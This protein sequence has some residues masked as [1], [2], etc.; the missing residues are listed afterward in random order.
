MTRA[1]A[2]PTGDLSL[3]ALTVHL[4]ETRGTP[5]LGR[6][7]EC[8]AFTTVPLAYSLVATFAEDVVDAGK[9]AGDAGGVELLYEPP[10]AGPVVGREIGVT[11]GM[12]YWRFVQNGLSGIASGPVEGGVATLLVP[13]ADVITLFD[14]A[15]N[16]VFQ[17]ASGA[18]EGVIGGSTSRVPLDGAPI[19]SALASE[20]DNVYCRST[21]TATTSSVHVWSLSGGTSATLLH[22]LP[23]G[24]AFAADDQRLYFS[25]D[26]GFASQATIEAT[27][28]FGDGG[29]PP[30]SALAYNRTSPRALTALATS[31]LF[32]LEDPGTGAT[33]ALVSPKGGGGG[34]VRLS[35][36][37]VRMVAADPTANALFIGLV[38]GGPAGSSIVKASPST[39]TTATI[40]A[41][42]GV[43]GGLA[44]DGAYLYFTESD[45]RVYRA[46]KP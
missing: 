17:H 19:C 20:S 15:T 9:E 46:P 36:P 40:R 1:S 8:D 18:L 23:S 3:A 34:Q 7:A 4:G 39:P 14:V 37:S 26:P 41:Q 21:S 31:Y 24:Y 45:G 28:R 27:S 12:L 44:V 35:S 2:T 5:P 11:N 32:W 25:R 13:P 29:V 6:E 33:S 16:V 22:T 10:V 42:L 38:N 43:L 30:S